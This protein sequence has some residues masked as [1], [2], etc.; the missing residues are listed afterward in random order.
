MDTKNKTLSKQEQT[1]R[2]TVSAILIALGTVLSMIKVFSM[3]FGG[4]VTICSM[5]PLLIIGGMYG[6]KWGL[7]SGLVYGVLQ[8]ILGATMSQAFAGQNAPSIVLIFILDYLLAYT[9]VGL[10]GM[11]LRGEKGKVGKLVAGSL[12]A[13]CL[14]Y[15]CH[16]V[17]GAIL[18]GSW[19]EWY[20]SQE[21]FYSWGQT[22]LE[23][24]SGTD[25]S[26]IYSA[27]Y[28][29]FYLLPEVIITMVVAV[30]LF[31]VK[32]LQKYIFGGVSSKKTEE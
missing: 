4:S 26:I 28:N 22:I 8:G 9:V 16:F 2:L 17:S 14:R 1:M 21:G 3:P 6:V 19:A 7:L 20:F 12:V 10:S 30:I 31:S 25:L 11:F 15:V 29:V 27:I 13:M 32:P 5:L 24:F 23:K 18:Y